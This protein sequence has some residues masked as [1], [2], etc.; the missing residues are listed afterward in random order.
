VLKAWMKRNWISLCQTCR[1]YG[2]SLD[3]AIRESHF[4]RLYE[5]SFNM[6][7]VPSVYI[8]EEQGTRGIWTL[9]KSHESRPVLG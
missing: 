4:D 9:R 6:K 1:T 5:N 3:L 7:Q 2:D 8:E